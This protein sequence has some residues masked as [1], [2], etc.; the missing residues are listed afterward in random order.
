[1]RALL[2]RVLQR[3][4]FLKTAVPTLFHCAVLTWLPEQK[5]TRRGPSTLSR[6]RRYVVLVPDFDPNAIVERFRERAEAVKKRGMPPVEGPERELFIEQ[7]RVDYSD[8]AMLGDAEA[9]LEDGIL[10]FS[11]DLRPKS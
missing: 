9:R 10:T 2:V 5:Q 7:A 4:C 8:F 6:G 3:T 1:M 11:V